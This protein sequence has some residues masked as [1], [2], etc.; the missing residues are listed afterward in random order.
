MGPVTITAHATGNARNSK[1]AAGSY[2]SAVGPRTALGKYLAADPY[3][4]AR[5]GE[6]AP[7]GHSADRCH[8]PNVNAPVAVTWL[9]LR[10]MTGS[11]IQGE[12]PSNSLRGPAYPNENPEPD[13]YQAC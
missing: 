8:V 3:G 9:R 2:Q 5:K 12:R 6:H 11:H 10:S 13:R 4:G 7:R 1:I